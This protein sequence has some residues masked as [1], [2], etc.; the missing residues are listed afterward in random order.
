MRSIF[1]LFC[2]YFFFVRNCIA[3]KDKSTSPIPITKEE[4]VAFKNINEAI[5]K[6]Q[7]TQM[8]IARSTIPIKATAA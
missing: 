6:P 8:K 5:A 2:F 7:C 4:A 3:Q 1:I